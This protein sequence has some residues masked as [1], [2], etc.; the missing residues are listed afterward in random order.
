MAARATSLLALTAAAILASPITVAPQ[1][2]PLVITSVNVVDVAEGRIIPNST[3][4]VDGA[5]IESVT[6][7]S[8]PA[9]D[10]RVVDGRGKFLIPGLWDMHAHTDAAGESS[11]Q[12][13]V[14]NG[15][16]GIRDMGSDLELILRLREGTASRRLLGPRI[17]AAGPILDDAPGEWPF[18]MR[19]RNAREGRAAVQQLK[20]RGVDFVKVHNHTPRDAFIAIA[21]EARRQQLRVAGHVPLQVTPREAIDAGLTNIEHLSE[22]RLWAPCSGGN[23]YR[24]DACRVFIATLARL[25][26]WQ[27]PTLVASEL[28]TI[29]TPNSTVSAVQLLYASD[30]LR[31]MWAANQSLITNPEAMRILKARR[32][33]SEAMT[34][35]LAKAG[36]EILAGCDAVIP[37]FCLHDEL[38][39][40]VGGAGMTPLAALQAA[41][42]NPARYLGLESTSGTV[43]AGKTAD[44]VLLDGN[45]LTDIANVRKI[46]AVVVRGRLLDRAELENVLAKVKASR[47]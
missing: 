28:V 13:H 41:T 7:G 17:V 31:A 33:A 37:G 19:V 21:D 11:L 39:A 25:G 1:A 45:P 9:R 16:T 4:R 26:I 27:T 12:L 47:R 42:L 3:V 14:A 18:R 38:A 44:L 40:F 34:R 8:R 20:R 2:P 43:A 22:G 15:V 30:R 36:V 35:D 32:Q 5:K 24:P 23:Q 6:Q 29:G 46:R 10:A